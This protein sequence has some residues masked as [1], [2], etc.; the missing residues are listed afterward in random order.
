MGDFLK[1]ELNNFLHKNPE[2]AQTIL[3]KIILKAIFVH[4]IFTIY[5]KNNCL[6]F[7]SFHLHDFNNQ[8]FFNLLLSHHLPSNF[9]LLKSS[10]EFFTIY[11]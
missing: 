11:I 5:Q 8:L 9:L 6:N 1:T 2:V 10:K 7:F 4:S 3:Y